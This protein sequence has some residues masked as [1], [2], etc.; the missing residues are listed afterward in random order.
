MNAQSYD[1]LDLSGALGVI[2]LRDDKIKKLRNALSQATEL[3]ISMMDNVKE[4]LIVIDH[5]SKE[6][7]YTNSASNCLFEPSDHF[8]LDICYLKCPIINI[9]SQYDDSCEASHVHDFSCYKGKRLFKINSLN[10]NWGGKNCYAHIIYD[11]TKDTLTKKHLEGLAYKD[12]HTGLY[13]RRFCIALINELLCNKSLFSLVYIDIDRLKYVNDTFGH[14]VGDDYIKHVCSVLTQNI[15]PCDSVCRIGGDEFILII[16]NVHKETAETKL[17]QI[18][19]TILFSESSYPM[20]ISYGTFEV[21]CDS[22]FT[23]DEILENADRIMYDFKKK[24]RYV[25]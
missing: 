6:I 3:L 7:V 23:P 16:P 19:K 24:H 20:S 21:N 11:I 10:I 5:E 12:E 8:D 13:N 1:Y 2:E 9:L 17:E 25:K 18:Y 22:C 14:N 15:S 4:S